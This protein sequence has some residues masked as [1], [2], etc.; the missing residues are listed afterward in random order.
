MVTAIVTGSSTGFGD[1]MARGPAEAGA[2]TVRFKF[3]TWIN[4][5]EKGGKYMEEVR[6]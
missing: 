3:S 6:V 5:N 2:D 4:L 1:A